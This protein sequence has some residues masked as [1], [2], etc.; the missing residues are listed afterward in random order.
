MEYNKSKSEEAKVIET[1]R[2]RDKEREKERLA[3][4]KVPRPKYR[5]RDVYGLRATHHEAKRSIIR[6]E[7]KKNNPVRATVY[8]DSVPARV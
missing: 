5:A 4:K 1:I 3:S 8:V 2:S 6:A 7:L